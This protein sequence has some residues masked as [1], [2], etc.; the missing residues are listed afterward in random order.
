MDTNPHLIPTRVEIR[1]GVVSKKCPRG[2]AFTNPTCQIPTL[3]NPGGG[4]G[5]GGGGEGEGEGGGGGFVLIG[6]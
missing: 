2:G 5:G 1:W 4:G 6:A 3:I